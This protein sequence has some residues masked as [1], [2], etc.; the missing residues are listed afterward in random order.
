MTETNEKGKEKETTERTYSKKR[1]GAGIRSRKIRESISAA[2]AENKNDTSRRNAKQIHNDIKRHGVR[3]V[4]ENDNIDTEH[5]SNVPLLVRIFAWIAL[6]AILFALGYGGAN[7]LF[8][9]LDSKTPGRIGNVVAEKSEI[10]NTSKQ[11]TSLAGKKY[12]LFVPTAQGTYSN[13]T[14]TIPTCT[15]E[16]GI[17]QI[18]NMYLNSL[19]E[20]KTISTEVKVNNIF[21]SGD[22]V[23][24]DF[25]SAL[26]T[27]L[28]KLN[29]EQGTIFITGLLKTI[30]ENFVPIRKIKIYINGKE[31][32][33]TTP[34]NITEPW[35]FN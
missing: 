27:S 19:K 1:S 9:W 8:N 3:K 15:K 34:I 2:N 20:T 14:V 7:C 5:K 32:K 6:V 23:Y 28:K 35:E 24:I 33:M 31:S 25:T 13:R 17:K 16:K 21:I 4:I 18:V 11:Q 26:E 10:K 12:I 29:A 22:W 30:K